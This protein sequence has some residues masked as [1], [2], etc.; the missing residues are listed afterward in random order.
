MVYWTCLIV[1]HWIEVSIFL[2]LCAEHYCRDTPH[3]ANRDIILYIFLHLLLH[4][5]YILGC[6]HIKSMKLFFSSYFP[7][8]FS[9]CL[10]ILKHNGFLCFEPLTIEYFTITLW[11]IKGT[12]YFY[13]PINLS[14]I[15]NLNITLVF[16]L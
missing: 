7:F 8:Q 11:K 13:H 4:L 12:H 10:S 1:L 9:A 6:F 5:R 3:I 16:K 14:F 2:L 15:S